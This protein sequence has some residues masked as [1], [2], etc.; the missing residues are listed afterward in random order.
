MPLAQDIAVFPADQPATGGTVSIN[1]SYNIGTID[2]SARTSNTMTLATGTQTPAIYGNWINGAGTAISGTGVLTFA[3]RGSQTITSAGKTFSQPLTIDSPSGPVSQLDALISGNLTTALNLVSGIYDANGYNF[4]ASGAI[5]V[6]GSETRTLALGSGTW[7]VSNYG[8]MWQVSGTNV[9]VTGTGSIRMT[10]TI[11]KTF[12][13]GNIQTYPTLVQAGTGTLTIT[14]SNKFAD[15]TNTAIGRV[16]FTGGTT[17]E[18]GDFNLN[19]VSGNLL[20][21]GSTNTTQAILKKPG[22]WNVG[23]NSTNAGNNTGLTFA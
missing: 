18:F 3:G 21:V 22:A 20:Q 10:S 23:A 13:G 2:M 15:I 1:A 16:Q 9:T 12:S 11:A 4:A 17:N 19:G 8:N 6:N 5:S 14:G 7:T